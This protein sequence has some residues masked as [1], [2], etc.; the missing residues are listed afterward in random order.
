M[1][2]GQEQPSYGPHQLWDNVAGGCWQSLHQC[3]I[4][5]KSCRGRWGI[6]L[7]QLCGPLQLINLHVNECEIVIVELWRNGENFLSI[8]MFC[9]SIRTWECNHVPSAET[10]SLKCWD[11]AFKAICKAR[12]VC[13]CLILVCR[14]WVSSS[15]LHCPCWPSH[16]VFKFQQ[17]F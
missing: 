12:Q 13:F 6:A 2:P 15:K 1:S 11:E 17:P 16:L 9:G 7:G 3:W 5:C 14:C 8:V 10:H 4:H